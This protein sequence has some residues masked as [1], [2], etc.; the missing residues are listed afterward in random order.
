MNAFEFIAAQTWSAATG[1]LVENRE[2]TLVKSGGIDVL[3]RLKERIDKPQRVLSLR[4]LR[5]AKDVIRVDEANRR[6]IIPALATLTEVS[7]HPEIRAR[8]HVLAEAIGVA[9]TPQVRNV[10]TIGGNLC[11]KPR[12]WYYRSEDFHCLKKGGDTCYAIA[13][14][15]RFHAIFGAGACHI[16]HP[17]NAAMGLSAMKALI[18]TVR[19]DGTKQIDR[20]IPIDDFYRVPINPIDDEHVL[21]PGE[22]VREIHLPFD[23]CGPRTAFIEVR[24]KQSFDWPLVTAAVNL[25]VPLEPQ[26]VLGAVAPIPWRLRKIEQMLTGKAIDADLIAR[27]RAAASEGA[28][29][30][31]GNAYKLSIVGPCVERAIVA[32]AAAR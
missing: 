2:G 6:I 30:M 3:D 15:N 8:A 23:Y 11:Q 16:V 21:E 26:V 13:G 24:E 4:Q 9:A 27:A 28:R 7:E 25:N 31:S 32:A 20:T 14:D 12:C 1:A 29:P 17:S 5:D 10:A 18:R 22:L 19:S